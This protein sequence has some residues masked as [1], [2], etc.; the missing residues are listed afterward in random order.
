[1]PQ[2]GLLVDIQVSEVPVKVMVAEVPLRDAKISLPDETV[3]NLEVRH[4]PERLT[5]VADSS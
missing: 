2:R 4:D 1:M 5:F 3:V